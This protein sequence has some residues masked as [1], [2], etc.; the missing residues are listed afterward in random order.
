[1]FHNFFL[2][3]ELKS[4]ESIDAYVR[5]ETKSMFVQTMASRLFG[6]NPLSGPYCVI[7]TFKG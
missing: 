4:L 3:T 7:Q 1:M 6:D 5:Q 2:Y